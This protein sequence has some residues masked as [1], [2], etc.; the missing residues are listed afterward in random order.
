M[1]TGTLDTGVELVAEFDGNLPEQTSSAR[2]VELRYPD[3][4]GGREVDHPYLIEASYT[5]EYPTA[6]EKKT[7]VKAWFLKALHSSTSWYTYG[8]GAWGKAVSTSGSLV[9]SAGSSTVVTNLFDISYIQTWRIGVNVKATRSD[10]A[11]QSGTWH[12]KIYRL[13]M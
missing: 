7:V 10:S 13:S 4:P 6:P 11:L 2:T 12:F 5:G 3:S 9:Y 1:A 8:Y